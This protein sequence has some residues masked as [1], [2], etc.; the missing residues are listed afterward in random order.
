MQVHDELVL[1]VAD[2]DVELVSQGLNQYMSETVKL[3]VP[4]LVEVGVG[5]N[6]GQAH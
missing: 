2:S 3:D 1:E 5:E 6:W 4:L